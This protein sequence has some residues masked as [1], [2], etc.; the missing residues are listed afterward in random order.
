MKRIL[1]L[2]LALMLVVAAQTA[3]ADEPELTVR[4]TGVVQVTA[5]RATIVLGVRES[6]PDVREAQ[7]TVNEK[8]NAVYNALIG[9]GIDQKDIGT[10]SIYIYANYDYSGDEERIVGYTATNTLSISTS[11]IDKVGEYIDLAF[12]AGANT[13]D[14]IDFSTC[15]SEGAQK[16]ALKLAVQNALEKAEIIAESA[17]KK[18]AGI[19]SIDEISDAYYYGSDTGA[20]YSNYRATEGAVTADT[21]VQA[22]AMQISAMVQ[23]E[24]ELTEGK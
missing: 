11:N 10:Q 3:L 2:I 8:I 19:V 5:D 6:D 12:E 4:G 20:K 16:E 22:S 18:V 21:L 13:L 17:G 9:A 14:N 7:T 15:N 23:I 1:S 24:F